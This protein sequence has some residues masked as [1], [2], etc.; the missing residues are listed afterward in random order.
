MTAVFISLRLRQTS[1]QACVLQRATSATVRCG[2][3]ATVV[4][5]SLDALLSPPDQ[6]DSMRE[7]VTVNPEFHV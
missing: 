4:G 3:A 6:R 7:L 5:H 1:G 2:V